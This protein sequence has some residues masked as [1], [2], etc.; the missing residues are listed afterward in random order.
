MA[1]SASDPSTR[2]IAGSTLGDGRYAVTRLLGEGSQGQTLEAID[3]L[4]G[5]LVA[6]KRFSIRGAASWK[7]VELAEREARVLA[8]LD[9]PALPKHLA[10]FEEDGALLLVMSLVEGETLASKREQ[11]QLFSTVEVMQLLWQLGGVLTYLHNRAPPVIHRDVKPRN[12][13]QRPDGSFALVDFGSVRDRLKADG[14]TVV[15]T[16]GFMAPE[17]F[18][19]R[20]LPVTDVYGLGATAL[21]LLTGTAPE[22]QPHQGLAIDVKAA[23]GAGADPRVVQLLSSMLH[24]DPDQRLVD[25]QP[26]MEQLFGQRPE[27]FAGARGGRR[28]AS[29]SVPPSRETPRQDRQSEREPSSPGEQARASGTS[30]SDHPQ[31]ARGTNSWGGP[32]L[33]LVLVLGLW[34]ARVATWALMRFS[35]PLLL[36]ALSLVFGEALR[37]AANKVRSVGK[38]GDEGLRRASRRVRSA[39]MRQETTPQ[40]RSATPP[41]PRAEGTAGSA[42]RAERVRVDAW[43]N[44]QRQRATVRGKARVIETELEELESEPDGNEASRRR[45]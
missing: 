20:A 11:G 25:L 34:T 12:I 8:Q 1:S 43:P 36:I 7:D 14:S 21:V 40:P 9:H 13:L 15:G 2:V 39:G 27:F 22:D 37:R 41:P 33:V 17:Q 3:K 45:R 24:P 42:R 29:A 35:L 32:V 30:G 44:R 5:Q 28:A 18:Q 23:L 16:F 38:R 6:I 19:G 4:N 10:Q 31:R 26:A